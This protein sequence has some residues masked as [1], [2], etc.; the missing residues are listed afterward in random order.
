MFMVSPEVPPSDWLLANIEWL[1]IP[2]MA[3]FG[4][5]IGHALA[6]EE[7]TIRWS[8]EQHVIKLFLACLKSLFIAAIALAIRAEYGGSAPL[9]YGS[10]SIVCVFGSETIKTAYRFVMR[11]V[12]SKEYPSAS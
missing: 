1:G 8:V 10:V 11:R 2:G 5:V 7:A 9:Y 3:M 12:F 4:G 6:Y